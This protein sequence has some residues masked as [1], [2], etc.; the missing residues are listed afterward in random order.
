MSTHHKSSGP[1]HDLTPSCSHRS[2]DLAP[3]VLI[4]AAPIALTLNY[5]APLV[6]ITALA[7]AA[8]NLVALNLVVAAAPLVLIALGFERSGPHHGPRRGNC[9]SSV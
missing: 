7:L 5:L 6:L 4:T 2:V 8:V 3:L 9:E 1:V